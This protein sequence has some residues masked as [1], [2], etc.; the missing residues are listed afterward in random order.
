MGSELIGHEFWQSKFGG[1]PDIVGKALRLDR[2]SHTV[3]GVLPPNLQ[4][5]PERSPSAATGGGGTPD[6][7][8]FWLPMQ[9]IQGSDRT[10]RGARMFVPIAR[11]KP[12][13]TEEAARAE[14]QALGRRLAADHP[15]TNGGKTFDLVSLR[16]RIL[17]NTK[18]GIPLLGLAVAAV[19]MICCV[20]LA[21]LLLAR[22]AK[23]RRELAVRVALGA[24]RA[25]IIQS[26]VTQSILLSLLGG[27]LGILLAQTGLRGI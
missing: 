19:L 20:N 7:Q 13:L 22:G 5:P 15:E 23:Q 4:F 25:R 2:K 26:L 12:K 6:L 27:A 16:D 24:S 17:G 10:S 21:N 9:E 18:Q 11:L 1:T 8:A 14:L 3:I